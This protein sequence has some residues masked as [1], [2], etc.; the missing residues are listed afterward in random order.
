MVREDGVQ[1]G[2]FNREVVCLRPSQSIRC[3]V[4]PDEAQVLTRY[5]VW[6][7]GCRPMTQR[8]PRRRRRTVAGSRAGQAKRLAEVE[9]T[10]LLPEFTGENGAAVGRWSGPHTER[11]R[12]N[13]SVWAASGANG[14]CTIR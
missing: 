2:L 13:V 3:I 12:R 4:K 5:A 9:G 6:P 8:L 1:V 7:T 11:V 10:A 14:V